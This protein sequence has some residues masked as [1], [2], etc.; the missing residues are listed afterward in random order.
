M[1]ADVAVVGGGPAGSVSALLLARAGFDVTIVERTRFPRRKAC[2]EYLNVGALDVLEGIGVGDAVRRAGSP[3]RGILLVPPAASPVELHFMRP[4]LALERE[5]LDAILLDAARSAGARLVQSRAVDVTFDGAGRAAGIVVRDDEGTENALHARFVVGADGAG[6]HV[7][8]KLGLVRASR[9]PRR[10]AVGGHYRGFGAMDGLVEM[11][12]GAGAYFAVNPLGG[13]RA[14]VMVVVREQALSRWSRDVDGGVSGKAAELGRG[15][16]SF[17]G[18]ERVG[19]RVAV[20]PLAFDT[21]AT[22]APGAL[23]VGDAAGFLNPFTGQGVYLALTG[24]LAAAGT[25][26]AALASRGGEPAVLAEYERSRAREMRIRRRLSHMVTTLIDVPF[27]ARR[28]TSRIARSP[29]AADGLLGALSGTSPPE[30]ALS[31]VT[32]ARLLL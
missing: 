3:L 29:R 21:A 1:T 23:L 24:A 7:A 31:P 4:A 19:A 27:L 14:N 28:A 11:Y 2:G 10:F 6:S 15:H 30:D 8:R 13:D 26:A 18:A 5:T 25:V 17:A 22:A 9:G 12:V 20:G 32:I 16:R